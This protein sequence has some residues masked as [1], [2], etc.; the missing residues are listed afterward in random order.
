MDSTSGGVKMKTME[1]Y[2]SDLNESAKRKFDECFGEP[3]TFNHEISPLAI[4][5]MEDDDDEA[6]P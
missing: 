1:V 6:L 4:Y 3:D 5:E 2:Y